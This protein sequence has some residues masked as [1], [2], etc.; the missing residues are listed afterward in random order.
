MRERGSTVSRN[1][2]KVARSLFGDSAEREAFLA[3]LASGDGARTA[4]A[5]IRGSPYQ[6]S[7]GSP[8]PP[9]LPEWI[10]VADSGDRPGKSERHD[11]G[12]VYCLDLSSTFACAALSEVRGPVPLL[13]DLCA[14]P[15][16]KSILA[17]RYLSPDFVVANEAIRKRS[18]QLIANFKRCGIDPSIVVSRDPAALAS[19][20]PQAADVVIVDA[21][22]SGQSLVLKD[23]AA[24]GAFHPATIS[25]N[26][27]RQRRIL[28]CAARLV[29]PGG[30]L[31]YSTCTFSREENEEVIEWLL[32]GH[33][34]LSLLPVGLLTAFQSGHA[35]GP[36]YRLFP[37]DGHG[38]GAFCA[39]LKSREAPSSAEQAFLIERVTETLKPIWRSPVVFRLCPVPVK[40]GRT[41]EAVR[42]GGRKWKRER[43]E[44]AEWR[45]KR[46][47][48]D[49][50]E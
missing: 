1:A 12:E 14:A 37:Q 31:L 28:A 23:R 47:R 11:S 40:E 19:S 45:L 20:V 43:R 7:G 6:G 36:M 5:A 26:A 35:D 13:L 16:G 50:N 21:P 27:R 39:L 17:S 9:W 42:A 8:R 18:S 49:D 32:K 3:A 25:M 33:P 4:V 10:I 38:A 22:C 15:G 30:H 48:A 41:D 46:A 24:P 44:R 2:E 29:R 34:H